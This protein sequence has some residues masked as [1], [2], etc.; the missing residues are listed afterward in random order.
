MLYKAQSDKPTNPSEKQMMKR[1]ISSL[2]FTGCLWAVASLPI[3]I[4]SQPIASQAQEMPL[5]AKNDSELYYLYYGQKISLRQRDNAIAVAFKPTQGLRGGSLSDMLKQDLLGNNTRELSLTPQADKLEIEVKALGDRYALIEFSAETSERDRKAI[6]RKA[7]TRSYVA[8]TLPVL[9]RND[10]KE[11]DDEAI[12]LPNE[13]TVSFEPKL[14]ASQI[15]LILNRGNLE[16]V[17]PLRFTQ[18]RYIVR[19]RSATGTD[20]L[21]ASN[22]LNGITGVKSATPNFVQSLS[23]KFQE[24]RAGKTNFTQESDAD[25]YLQKLRSRYVLANNSTFFSNL[26]SLQWHLNSTPQRGNYSPRTD[27]RATE[28]WKN[29]KGGDGIVVAV[30]DSL[31]QWDHPDLID[32]VYSTANV[33]D[34]LPNEVNGWDFTGKNGGDPDTRISKAEIEK[35]RTDFQSTFQFSNA[36][37]IKRYKQFANSLK[38]RNPKISEA[39]IA[40]QI[41]NYIRSDIASEFHGT[42]SAGVIAAHPKNEEGILGVAPNAKILPVRVFGL[43]GEISSNNLVEAIGYSSDRGAN[44]INMS[45]GGLLPDQELTDQIFQI[46][47]K[48][49]NLVI[50]ASAGNESLD[51]VGFPSAIPGVLSVGST[52][53]SGN[54]SFYSS[55][56]GRLDVVAPGGETNQNSLGGILTTGGTWVSGFWENASPPKYTWE[57]ALDPYGKYVRVQGT[58]F[59]APNVAGVVALMRGENANIDRE[60]LIAILKRTASYDGLE[61]SS[62]DANKYRLQAAI[63]FSTVKD[64][65]FVRPSGIY[66]L[67]TPISA[68]QYY[69]GSGLVN[70]EAAVKAVQ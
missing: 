63:G 12:I 61:I 49:P 24:Q 69:F 66:Q 41:R 8:S 35:L 27:L 50:V 36:A 52:N 55:F 18:N 25:Q 10:S 30:I 34:K 58:S 53:I 15:Q 1:I 44:V 51:G 5:S 14:A 38:S 68:M 3:Q 48:N 6:T 65:P 32:N 26:L 7:G 59:S 23:Y 22:Q 37:L 2:C 42:W 16:I 70:A 21:T 57:P 67:P 33:K 45:L 17:R 11:R 39:A 40:K 13:I 60:N 31:I 62:N 19:S 54:R 29:S 46:L 4:T 9:S 56:G 43:N 20:I 47:D 64:F 28:A